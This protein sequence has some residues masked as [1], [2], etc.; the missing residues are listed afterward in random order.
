MAIFT[1]RLHYY[2]IPTSNY[3]NAWN[4]YQGSNAMPN[5][6]AYT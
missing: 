3:Y 1:A 2:G 6:V 4:A 5:C